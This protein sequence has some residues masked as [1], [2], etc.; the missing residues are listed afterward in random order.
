MRKLSSFLNLPNVITG[1]RALLVFLIIWTYLNLPNV[2]TGLR[3]FLVFPI[4]WT[5]SRGMVNV[6]FWLLIIAAFTDLLDGLVARAIK[7]QTGFGK[8][9]DPLAD[10]VLIIGILVCIAFEIF[11]DWVVVLTVSLEFVLA[12]M[13]MLNFFLKIKRRLGSN[14]CGKIK[15]SLQV[16]AILI[17]FYNKDYAPIAEVFLQTAIFFAAGSIILHA[18]TKEKK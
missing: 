4:I 10:K 16:A 15:M 5:Y 3:A 2:I 7:Q 18:L 13:S 11:S 9:F 17:V 6:A 1:L 12:G 14:I 8:L